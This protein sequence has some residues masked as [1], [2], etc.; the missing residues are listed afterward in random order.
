M[1]PVHAVSPLCT[2]RPLPRRD[3][4]ET[5]L[6]G[7]VKMSIDSVLASERPPSCTCRW[8]TILIPFFGDN[9]VA[10]SL[11]PGNTPLSRPTTCSRLLEDGEHR[12]ADLHTSF[13][14]QIKGTLIVPHRRLV[15]G[16]PPVLQVRGGSRP[17]GRETEGR[18]GRRGW[19]VR[20][21]SGEL[22]G[23]SCVSDLAGEMERC[24]KFC[25]V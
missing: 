21:S 6:L 3:I 24:S 14:P 17:V 15:K 5:L 13:C 25:N 9:S 22:G 12:A 4:L 16:V 8:R 1:Q 20:A 2:L 11:P 19:N 18:D 23:N 7:V 10:A